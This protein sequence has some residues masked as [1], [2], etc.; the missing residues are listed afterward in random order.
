MLTWTKRKYFLA[1]NLKNI[2]Q[3]S[4]TFFRSIWASIVLHPEQEALTK[5]ISQSE[6][7]IYVSTNQKPKKS[8][9]ASS[10]LLRRWCF[11]R[12]FLLSLFI[13]FWSCS[14]VFT[15]FGRFLLTAPAMIEPMKR[16]GDMA[17]VPSAMKRPRMELVSAAQ[18]QQLV[19]SVS[20]SNIWDIFIYLF[21]VNMPFLW[22]F[23]WQE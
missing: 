18:S 23:K 5:K 1:V 10:C 8:G 12:R 4:I 22:Y 15:R 11:L 17:V 14:F 7:P 9:N 6:Q 16:P 3:Y 13:H 21:I 19:A 20:L 2:L